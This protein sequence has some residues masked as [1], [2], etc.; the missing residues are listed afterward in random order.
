MT[1]PREIRIRI[2]E[3]RW[4]KPTAGLAPGYVQTSLVVLPRELAYDFLL[5]RRG[6]SRLIRLIRKGL[7]AASGPGSYQPVDRQQIG[8]LEGSKIGIARDQSGTALDRQGG[9]KGIGVGDG[10]P[11]LFDGLPPSPQGP[12]SPLG[13]LRAPARHCQPTASR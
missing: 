6:R 8:D 3:G 1:D 7:S 11:P 12:G 13:T 9:G 5:Y 4:R 2:R 10:E